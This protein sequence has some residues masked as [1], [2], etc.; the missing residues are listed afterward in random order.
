MKFRYIGHPNDPGDTQPSVEL[1]GHVF[2]FGEP[3]EVTSGRAIAKLERHTQFEAVPD[4]PAPAQSDPEPTL[5]Q[6]KEELIAIAEANDIKVDKRWGY[7]KLAE[8]IIA[9]TKGL[10]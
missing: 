8:A 2:P 9:H 10:S 4:G 7:D 5:P 6:T 1:F 3:V